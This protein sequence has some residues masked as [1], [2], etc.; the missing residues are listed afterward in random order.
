M[1]YKALTPHANTILELW[2]KRRSQRQK[3]TITVH[4]DLVD[5]SDTSRPDSATPQNSPNPAEVIPLEL[6]ITDPS[7]MQFSGAV[8]RFS[9]LV[10]NHI[11]AILNTGIQLQQKEKQEA[12]EKRRVVAKQ[13]KPEFKRVE[14]LSP[15]RIGTDGGKKCDY[16]IMKRCPM[17]N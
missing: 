4:S 12:R 9:S 10:S 15:T 5:G 6:D 16:D 7:C 13:S 14:G 3:V 17:N 2:R 8:Q 11:L 1:L